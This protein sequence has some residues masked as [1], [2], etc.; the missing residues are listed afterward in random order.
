MHDNFRVYVRGR[1]KER[2]KM[3]DIT[4]LSSLI[5]DLFDTL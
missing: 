5:F 4:I 3:V 2:R 1:I